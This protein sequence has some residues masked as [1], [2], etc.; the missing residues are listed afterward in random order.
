M[1]VVKKNA[2]WLNGVAVSVC[3]PEGIGK[4]QK[5]VQIT[6]IVEVGEQNKGGGSSGRLDNPSA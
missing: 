5:C 2:A 6:I 1:C 3:C 4:L